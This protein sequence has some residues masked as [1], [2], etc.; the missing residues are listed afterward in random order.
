MKSKKFE[1]VLFSL[2]VVAFLAIMMVP[3]MHVVFAADVPIECYSIC[4]PP[5]DAACGDHGTVADCDQ[6]PCAT[7]N[8]NSDKTI[9]SKC[10]APIVPTPN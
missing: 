7:K 1:T 10:A 9:V 8:T 6:S 5:Y 4:S 3:E 2:F